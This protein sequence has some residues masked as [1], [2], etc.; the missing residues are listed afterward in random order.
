MASIS[1]RRA[2]RVVDPDPQMVGAAEASLESGLS[3]LRRRQQHHTVRYG[4]IVDGEMTAGRIRREIDDRV[5]QCVV[6]GITG[7]EQLGRL[8]QLALRGRGDVRPKGSAR[9]RSMI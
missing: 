6:V 2:G 1:S 4:L 9:N 5:G 3:Q 7:T 8:E